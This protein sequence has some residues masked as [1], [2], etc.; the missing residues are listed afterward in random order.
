MVTFQ[1]GQS[2]EMS[3]SMRG[4]DSIKA[5]ALIGLVTIGLLGGCSRLR[6]LS[7]APPPRVIPTAELTDVQTGVLADAWT[8]ADDGN[9]DDALM[10]FQEL[11]AENP[12]ITDA[13]IGVGEIHLIKKDYVKAE[14]AFARAARLEPRNFDAQYGH[15]VALQML[16]RLFEAVRAY[17]RA[18]TIDPESVK[19]NLNL[20][21]TYL[22]LDDPERAV[23]FAERAVELDPANGPAHANLGAAYERVDRTGEA[24]NAYISAI[25]LMGNEP[26]LLTKLINALA[27]EDRYQEAVNTAETLIR[28]NPNAEAYERMGWC[29]FKLRQ[30]E[31]SMRAYQNAVELDPTYWQAWNGIGVN[32]LNAWLLSERTDGDARTTARDAFRRSLRVNAEQQ[33]LVALMLKYEL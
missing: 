6:Q 21:T 15:G 18:L 26:R 16:D 3:V 31:N 13:Y 29:A 19:A 2:R 11:L 14:P 22:Q 23:V 32:A 7:S 4:R 27:R 33:K 9:Y 28:I 10:L 5:G 20:A 24:V 30:Y 12:T 17:H 1:R 25:E 8:A